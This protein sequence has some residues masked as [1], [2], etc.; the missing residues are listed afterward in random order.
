MN[1]LFGEKSRKLSLCHFLFFSSCILV[2]I[3]AQKR[4]LKHQ[5]FPNFSVFDSSHVAGAVCE[6]SGP[7]KQLWLARRKLLEEADE[8]GISPKKSGPKTRLLG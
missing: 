2:H 4:L 5:G 8:A 3:A 1:V 6:G 7:W